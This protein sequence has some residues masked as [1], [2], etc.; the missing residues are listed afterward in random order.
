MILAE[1]IHVKGKPVGTVRQD[2]LTRQIAFTAANPP[3]KLPEREWVCV[4]EL[5]EAVLA[6]YSVEQ[7]ERGL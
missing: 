5:K 6:A 4:D 3:S 1:A 2:T 7:N